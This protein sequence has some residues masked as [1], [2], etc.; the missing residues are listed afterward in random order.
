MGELAAIYHLN[1]LSLPLP[2]IQGKKIPKRTILV[3]FKWSE[4]SNHDIEI[5]RYSGF[6]GEKQTKG[7]QGLSSVLFSLYS[8]QKQFT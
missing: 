5:V 6:M 3:L 4:S 2:N 7:F 8:L 1:K